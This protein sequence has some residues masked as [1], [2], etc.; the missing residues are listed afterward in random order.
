MKPLQTLPFSFTA[1]ASWAPI[2][3]LTKDWGMIAKA[4]D[5]GE[6]PNFGTDLTY[7]CTDRCLIWDN[8]KSAAYDYPEVGHD[9]CTPTSRRAFRDCWGCLAARFTQD[10]LK[11][12]CDL[13]FKQAGISAL[14][15]HHQGC[16]YTSAEL[17]S[18]L[19]SSYGG[20]DVM[21]TSDSSGSPAHQLQTPSILVQG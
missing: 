14:I 21:L 6:L 19:C 20:I 7:G 8:V 9:F 12:R 5:T 4:F 16:P 15:R 3:D 10:S 18:K 11:A 2:R 1:L 17:H 13:W